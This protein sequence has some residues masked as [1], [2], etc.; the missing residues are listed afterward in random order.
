MTAL[1]QELSFFA[2]PPE[3]RVQIYDRVIFKDTRNRVVKAYRLSG[4]QVAVILDK[5]DRN[6]K[7]EGPHLD[8]LL[9]TPLDLSLRRTCRVIYLEAKHYFYEDM[10]LRIPTHRSEAKS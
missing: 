8:V 6:F 7:Y 4:D 2:L 5:D 3:I 10:I 1:N 9:R